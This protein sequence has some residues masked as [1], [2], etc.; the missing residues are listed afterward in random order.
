MVVADRNFWHRFFSKLVYVS[1]LEFLTEYVRKGQIDIPEFVVE[2]DQELETRP[3]MD[4]GLEV[5]PLQNHNTPLGP[6]YRGTAL[7]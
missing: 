7:R 2:H 5:D 3:L 1:R 6:A 4:Y